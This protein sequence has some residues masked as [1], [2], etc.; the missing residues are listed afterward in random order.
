MDM[1]GRLYMELG[2]VLWWRKQSEEKRKD[3]NTE[4]A[5]VPQSSRK[6]VGA[7]LLRSGLGDLGGGG[8]GAGCCGR[9]ALE[10]CRR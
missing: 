2:G 5:E 9:G 7:P 1:A 10:F 6:G 3:F 8:G 4:D